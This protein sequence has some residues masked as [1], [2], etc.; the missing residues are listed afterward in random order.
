MSLSRSPFPLLLLALAFAALLPNTA[1]CRAVPLTVLH[2]FGD[3]GPIRP[4]RGDHTALNGARPVAALLQGVDGALYGTSVNGGAH[5]QG[6]VFRINTDGTG[7]AV[8]HSFDSLVFSLSGLTNEA[9]LT[10]EGGAAVSGALVQAAGGTLYG[11]AGLGGSAG[12]GVVFKLSPNGAGFRVIHNFG[13]LGENFGRLGEPVTGR[14]GG[15][16]GPAALTLGMDGL[17]YGVALLGGADGGGVVFR[18]G[19]DGKDFKVLHAFQGV[20]HATDTNEDG[21]HP[22]AAPVFGR[23]GALYGTTAGG[24][25]IGCGVLYRLTPDGARFSVLHHFQR[26]GLG[27]EGEAEAG[28]VLPEG[29]LTASPDG[30][31]YGST[32][33]GGASGGGTLFR[34]GQDGA[35][36]TLL[37]AFPGPDDDGGDGRLPAATPLLGRDG[38]LYGLTGRGGAGGVGTLYWASPDGAKFVVLHDFAAPDAAYHNADG[39]YPRAGLIQGRDGALYG[40]AAG[41][42]PDGTGTVFRLVPPQAR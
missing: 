4:R 28:G 25:R 41:G 26:R 18:L 13:H 31:L 20:A 6:A 8:L 39:A 2:T 22:V 35:G 17:L 23:D 27:A 7:F 32:G 38:R 24:G 33:L 1:P 40:V 16:A 42:G 19:Q 3:G 30:F 5:G 9:G 36:F 37:R 21:A 12:G 10:N 34:I 11:V 29:A 14:N 15:G